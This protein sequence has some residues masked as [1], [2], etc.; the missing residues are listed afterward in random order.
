MGPLPCVQQFISENGSTLENAVVMVNHVPV[1]TTELYD[2]RR[3]NISRMK[4]N[5][6]VYSGYRVTP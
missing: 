3:N 5:R 4:R 1:P 2:R 6:S